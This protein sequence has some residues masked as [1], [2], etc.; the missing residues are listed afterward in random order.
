MAYG[1]LY[2]QQITLLIRVL[3]FVAEETV[4][5]LKGGTAINLFVRDMPEMANLPAVKWRQRNLDTLSPEGR[6]AEVAKLEKVLFGA[7]RDG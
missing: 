6:T 3:P 5:A 2:R 4:F 1:N 7:G